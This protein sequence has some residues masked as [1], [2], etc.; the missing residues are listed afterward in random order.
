MGV[1]VWNMFWLEFSK[2]KFLVLEN[3]NCC[4]GW[5]LVMYWNKEEF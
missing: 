5:F 2:E 4:G 3:G 1:N